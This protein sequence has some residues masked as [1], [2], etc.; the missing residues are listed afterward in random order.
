MLILVGFLSE[1]RS[2]FKVVLIQE[3]RK[4]EFGHAWGVRGLTHLWNVVFG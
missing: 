4:T 2:P 1:S 3:K